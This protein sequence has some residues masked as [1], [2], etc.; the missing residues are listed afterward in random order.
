SQRRPTFRQEVITHKQQR[1]IA[2]GPNAT[3]YFE[4]ALT[5]KYQIQEMLRVERIFDA[6][7]IEEELSAYNPLIPDGSNWKATFM[8][9]YGNAEER[10]VALAKLGGIEET[11]WVQVD[12]GEKT[13]P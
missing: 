3:L 9:E 5:M 4:D 13:H 12:D 8:I 11:L 7:E 2:L 1:Q 10:R 6:S